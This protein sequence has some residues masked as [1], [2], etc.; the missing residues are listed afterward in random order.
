[1]A[2]IN[3]TVLENELFSHWQSTTVASHAS[4]EDLGQR[5]ERFQLSR[6]AV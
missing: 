4:R 1:M 5:T 6:N 2:M 3:R